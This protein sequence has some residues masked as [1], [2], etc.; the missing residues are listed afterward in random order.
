MALAQQAALQQQVP[1]AQAA[2]GQVGQLQRVAQHVV[3][4]IAHEGIAVHQQGAQ[5]THQ[6]HCQADVAC[7]ARLQ[8]QQPI[9]ATVAS[10]A[11]T[12]MPAAA[13]ATR[14]R[15]SENAEDEVASTYGNGR[16]HHQRD[17]DFM[18]VAARALIV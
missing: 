7:Q 16:E 9:S 10:S 2:R 3:A 18:H 4:V 11:S 15:L 6:H 5:A 13:T 14:S 12:K 8:H 17:A 1:P